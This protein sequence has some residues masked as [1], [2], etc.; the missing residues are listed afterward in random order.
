M[1]DNSSLNSIRLLLISSEKV[2]ERTKEKNLTKIINIFHHLRIHSLIMSN[3][4][5][6]LLENN[7]IKF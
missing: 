7:K 1:S 2:I 4:V 3:N 6:I 5:L